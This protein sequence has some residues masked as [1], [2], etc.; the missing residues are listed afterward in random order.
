MKGRAE[1]IFR[2]YGQPVCVQTADGPV[3]V[4]A[5]LR[6]VSGRSREVFHREFSMLGRAAQDRIV[7]I[8]PAEPALHAGMTLES[9][10][11]RCS[12]RRCAC[13]RLGEETIY[14]W[15]LLSR[16]GASDDAAD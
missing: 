8:G 4:C 10:G 13:V 12:V 9:M 3:E 6:L 15:G 7:Y 2:R 5:F 16:E 11:M 1:E 14:Q